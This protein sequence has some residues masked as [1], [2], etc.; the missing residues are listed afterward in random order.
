MRSFVLIFQPLAYFLPEVPAEVLPIFDEA[1]RDVVLSQFPKYDRI[2]KEIR[3]RIADLPLQEEIR[4]FRQIHLNQLVRTFGVVTSSSNVLPQLSLVKYNCDKCNY[5]IGPFAQT[6]TAEVT[7][8]SCPECQSRGPFLVRNE[9]KP[10][11]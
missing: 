2:A 8:Q 7:P 3:V 9:F 5:V 10:F 11:W 4:D 6:Q 1:A